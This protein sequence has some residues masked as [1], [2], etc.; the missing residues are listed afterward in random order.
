MIIGRKKEQSDLL[1]LTNEEESQFCVVY[2]RRRIGKTFLIRETFAH[3]FAFQH[4][5]LAN[6]NKKEQLSEFKESLRTAGMRVNNTPKDWYEAFHLLAEHLSASPAG[7]K[8]VF[9][10]ELSWMD[11]PKSGFISALEHFWNGWASARAEKDIV[12]IV[13]GS[14]TSWIINKVIKNRGGLHNRLTMRIHLKPFTLK[15]CEE[16]AQSRNLPLS[17]KDIAETYMILGGVPYYWSFLRK[18]ESLAQNIDRMLFADEAPLGDEYSA[19]YAS[20]FK[21]PEPYIAIVETL[22]RKKSGMTRMELLKATRHSD[23]S[24]FTQTLSE[25]EQCNFIRKYNCYGKKE[26]ESG[27]QL[28]DN[29]TLFHFQYIASNTRHDPNY[30]SHCIGTPLYH[31]W[32]GLAFERLCLWHLPQITTA[33]GIKGVISS[34]HS[35]RTAADEE[36]EGAQIDLLIDRNDNVINL[37]EMKYCEEKYALSKDEAEKLQNRRLTF[38]MATRTRK[39]ILTTMVTMHGLFHNRYSNDIHSEVCVDELFV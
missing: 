29:F 17:R 26:R 16:Y 1:G 25:L 9:L 6:A 31:A 27:Y 22:A 32:A 37:C 39:S 11:T 10:D 20:L 21:H 7:K 38:L 4:T 33:L 24:I 8:V 35:W 2:G 12:L 14:A 30:W 34:A 5:G 23:N 19:L 3:R 18:N 28:I 13:C 36:H 15:E